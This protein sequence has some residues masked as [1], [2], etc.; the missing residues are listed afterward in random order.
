[1]DIL[2]GIFLSHPVPIGPSLRL[3][4]LKEHSI[5]SNVEINEHCKW[6]SRTDVSSGVFVTPMT[7]ICTYLKV[8]PIS[9]HPNERLL[10]IANSVNVKGVYLCD[11]S[12][13][14]VPCNTLYKIP[15]DSIQDIIVP[16]NSSDNYRHR[17]LRMINF[18]NFKKDGR[19]LSSLG[20]YFV[21]V[22][23]TYR[24]EISVQ[25]YLFKNF[26]DIST[27]RQGS[28][29]FDLIDNLD[30]RHLKSG[31]GQSKGVIDLPRTQNKES[32]FR[33]PIS[34]HD[35]YFG[36]SLPAPRIHIKPDTC[37]SDVDL[38]GIIIFCLP[39]DNQVYL[40]RFNPNEAES[41]ALQT[42][43]P[44]PY[45]YAS[46]PSPFVDIIIDPRCNNKRVHIY[47]SYAHWIFQIFR[48]HFFDSLSLFVG[49][50]L[51]S[52][53]L[54]LVPNIPR[55]RKTKC[56]MVSNVVICGTPNQNPGPNSKASK[57]LL[58]II[59]VHYAVAVTVYLLHIVRLSVDDSSF[60]AIFLPTSA[61]IDKER[62]GDLGPILKVSQTHSPLI[63]SPFFLL[64]NMCA[65][66][67]PVFIH[68]IADCH[69]PLIL[70]LWGI[71]HTKLSNKF[72]RLKLNLECRENLIS[73]YLILACICVSGFIHDGAAFLLLSVAFILKSA[74]IPV[75]QIIQS[76]IVLALRLRFALLFIYC[77][78]LCFEQ[79]ITHFFRAKT[80][81]AEFG[82]KSL[83]LYQPSFLQLLLLLHLLIVSVL[84][85]PKASFY[86]RRF[87]FPFLIV[88][89]IVASFLG[90][91]ACLGGYLNAAQSLQTC[92]SV[93]MPT[94]FS[95]YSIWTIAETVEL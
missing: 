5:L 48:V 23:I 33:L 52:V 34:L 60:L 56:K 76:P 19:H 25:S 64:H 83:M 62:R 57:R 36:P 47:Y 1:M 2:K 55:L 3:P 10:L 32:F 54:L 28:L 27:A 22:H 73:F 63:V 39:W 49:H 89:L 15:K 46:L 75:K 95:L 61:W 91:L 69:T 50:I 85:N 94:V 51:L 4:V 66:V 7:S 18:N 93:V 92:L 53:F 59:A 86:R 20:G 8:G 29:M 12:T 17:E 81:F 80:F 78:L 82:L 87:L 21:V 16:T 41:F 38:Y 43:T 40:H 31:K 72:D 24:M 71:S 79:W 58:L 9:G 88:A 14:S 6:I 44:I 11:N 65:I 74:S 77:S 90:C 35:Y 68:F 70:A 45:N 13:K 37:S 42:V 26:F 84:F 30:N 67:I